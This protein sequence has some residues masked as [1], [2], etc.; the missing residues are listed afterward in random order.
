[1]AALETTTDNT[2][3]ARTDGAP[4][5]EALSRNGAETIAP[6][7][8]D[9]RMSPKTS[10]SAA[11]VLP[12]LAIDTAASDSNK[13]GAAISTTDAAN[14]LAT[15][16][17]TELTKRM[18]AAK[19]L[20]D[21]SGDDVKAVYEEEFRRA[22]DPT[23]LKF[24][25]DRLGAN[26]TALETGRDVD[27]KA[28]DAERRM[29]LHFEDLQ[30]IRALNCGSELHF[31]YAMYLAGHG[32]IRPADPTSKS[33]AKTGS[34]DSPEDADA[35]LRLAIKDAD[36]VDAHLLKRTDVQINNDL[37]TGVGDQARLIEY[38]GELEGPKDRLGYVGLAEERVLDRDYLAWQYLRQ[39][40]SPGLVQPAV[41]L[42]AEAQAANE[43]IY[44]NGAPDQSTEQLQAWVKRAYDL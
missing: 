43:S 5:L 10:A 24:F 44:G 2:G 9:D 6:S 42:L 23:K 20:T 30:L 36:R 32:P 28:I 3:T 12:A 37:E 21:S 17:V 1:M 25:S 41:Q 27:G 8:G 14:D 4:G 16:S 33:R 19:R 26:L 7:P 40:E 34:L 29:A 39:G 35:Q 18:D 22:D 11:S 38:K 13:T 15:A 31:D